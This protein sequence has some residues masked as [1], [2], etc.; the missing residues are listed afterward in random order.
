MLHFLPD[1]NSISNSLLA[2]LTVLMA[3]CHLLVNNNLKNNFGIK[4]EQ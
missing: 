4:T 2:L 3:D 1:T